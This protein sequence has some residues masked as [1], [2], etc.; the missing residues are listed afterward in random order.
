MSRRAS[1]V[2]LRPIDLTNIHILVVDDH[3]DTLE[4]FSVALHQFGA[5]VLKARTARDALTIIQTVR[6]HAM[7][8]DLAMP[9]EDGLWLVQQLRR[10]K[11]EK[12]GSIPA[13]AV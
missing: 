8:S 3:E 12:G 11:Y 5:N 10:L 1:G 9:G 7:I 6:V 2:Q 13:I 4:L